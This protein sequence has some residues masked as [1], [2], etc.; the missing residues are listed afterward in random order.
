MIQYNINYMNGGMVMIELISWTIG[1]ITAHFILPALIEM[2][3]T[4]HDKPEEDRF[5]ACGYLVYKNGKRIK[6]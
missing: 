1:L 2:W 3:L 6:Q 5:D 4:P